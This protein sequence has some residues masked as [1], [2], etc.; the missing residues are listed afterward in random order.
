MK[1]QRRFVF[2]ILGILIIA[3]IYG[4]AVVYELIKS[5]PLEVVFFNI[6]QGDAIFIETP[7][8]Y[9]ILIDGGPNSVILEKL[10]KEMNFWDRTI[11]LIILT[12]P[13]HDHISGLIEVLKRYKV[14]NILR[15]GILRDTEEYK[16]W[17]RLIENEDSNVKIAEAGQRIITPNLFFEILYP[18]VSLEGQN[19]K[20][21]NNSS[22]IAR[23]VFNNNS[24]LF[25]GDA[26]KSIERKL[27]KENI[28]LAS[29]ILKVGHHGSK[30][31]TSKELLEV[32]SPQ[33]AVISA[34]KDNKYGHPHQEVLDILNDYGIKVLR[35][36]EIGDIKIISDGQNI[37]Y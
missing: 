30:T 2:L 15:T 19:I 13:E 5:Q 25:L 17:M 24:F 27:I 23:L 7:K 8:N 1:L 35:T 20:N 32:V 22:I 4:W 37:I 3:N 29:D 12:H 11:D 16:E 10:G 21:T 31:S 6:G 26:Y 34:G 33:T 28:Y 18:F 36:D 9:Q 14:E